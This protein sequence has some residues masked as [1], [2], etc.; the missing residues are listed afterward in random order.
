MTTSSTPSGR[1]A[2]T[3]SRRSFTASIT[4]QRVLAVAHDDDAAD[5]LA[6][7]VELG[8]PAARRRPEPHLGDVGDAHRGAALAGAQRH[9]LEVAPALDVAAAAHHDLVPG[10][11]EHL[12]ADLLVGVADR[13]HHLL[14]RDPERRELQRVDDDLVLATKPPTEAT[15]ATPGTLSSA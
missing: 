8:D 15:S 12:A 13:A 9:Q 6:L 4:A 2:R 10:E 14:E 7:A 1:L 5:R 3:S 11:L